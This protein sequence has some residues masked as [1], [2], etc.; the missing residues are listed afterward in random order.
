MKIET[1]RE[2][3]DDEKPDP[4]KHLIEEGRAERFLSLNLRADPFIE[5]ILGIEPDLDLLA[6][7][8]SESYYKDNE[9]SASEREGLQDALR[10]A[11]PEIYGNISE[12]SWLLCIPSCCKSGIDWEAIERL[13]PMSVVEDFSIDPLIDFRT[14]YDLVRALK[15]VELYIR[16]GM[17]ML[18]ILPL[19]EGRGP[20]LPP[21]EL[22]WKIVV[23]KMIIEAPGRFRQEIEIL[24]STE[25]LADMC[26]SLLNK[27]YRR[28]IGAVSHLKRI[29]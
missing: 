29:E 6:E 24:S 26:I 17:N 7:Y 4:V 14:P 28:N 19:L 20:T 25:D 1:V 3:W 27:R 18:C 12:P 5:D 2:K 13:L 23:T 16:S 9:V 8:V 10:K 15:S 21:R 11:M 22:F